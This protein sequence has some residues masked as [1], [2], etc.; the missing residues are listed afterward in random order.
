[1]SRT[2]SI[3]RKSCFSASVNWLSRVPWR[4]TLRRVA[5]FETGVDAQIVPSASVLVHKLVAMPNIKSRS[6]AR[7]VQAMRSLYCFVVV[8]VLDVFD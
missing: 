3:P 8:I 6:D 7:H 2:R 4:S 5:F 1:M